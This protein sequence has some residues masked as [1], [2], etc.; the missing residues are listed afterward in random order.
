[1]SDYRRVFV[2]G[3]TFF[4][5]IVTYNRQPILTSDLSRHILRRVWKIVQHK[6]PFTC[7]AICL[8]PEHL[9]CLWTLPQNDM[10]YSIRWSAIKAL[11]S[12]SYL[13]EGSKKEKRNLSRQ[14]KGEAAVWQRRYWEHCIRDDRDFKKHFDYIHYNPVK[15]NFVTNV[16][17]WKWSSFH[18]YKAK[19]Y[20]PEGWGKNDIGPLFNN[21]EFGE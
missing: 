11:F 8:L 9:H 15:H 4:F 18:T 19:G 13:Q 10:N 20:Y 17:E 6:H 1:M 7:D 21:G 14:R 12:K 16:C 2:H 3:G 5:T